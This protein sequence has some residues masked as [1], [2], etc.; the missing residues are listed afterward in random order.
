MIKNASSMRSAMGLSEQVVTERA[1]GIWQNAPGGPKKVA[2]K[3][4]FSGHDFTD[5]EVA[6]LLAGQ[7]ITFDAVSSKGRP[8][9]ATGELGLG[10]FKG[11]KYVGFQ[12]KLPD[13]PT[14]WCGHTFSVSE[15]AKLEAG[16]KIECTDFVSSKGKPFAARVSWDA[17]AKKIVPDFGSTAAST[18]PP[19]SW[20]QHTFSDAEKKKLAAGQTIEVKGFVSSKGKKF[21]AKVTWKEEEGRKKIVPSFG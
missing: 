6:A 15:K 5:D 7:T 14:M 12:L 10:D 21:D 13:G 11:R 8:Y 17:G 4:S 3:R 1:E 16:E 9:V 20:C 18:E 2:F 19:S